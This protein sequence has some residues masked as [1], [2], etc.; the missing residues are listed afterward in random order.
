MATRLVSFDGI[1][2]AASLEA[3]LGNLGFMREALNNS[4]A[5]T[6]IYVGYANG[7]FFMVRRIWNDEDRK[8][9]KAPGGTAYIVQSIEHAPGGS[10]GRFIYFDDK[11]AILRSED[12]PD[13][14]QAPTIRELESGT[15][16]PPRRADRSRRRPTFSSPPGKPGS[17]SPTAPTAATQSS[18]PT[19]DSQP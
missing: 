17:P 18:A 11:L 9:F 7:D 13:Y 1:T 4:P 6:S 16:P 8:F 5:L 14:P 15:R 12:R 2:Q 19:F 10:S 3:R